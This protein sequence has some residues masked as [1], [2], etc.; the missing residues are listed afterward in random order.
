MFK[1]SVVAWYWRDSQRRTEKHI[2][3]WASD[4]EAACRIA[5]EY[6]SIMD[7]PYWHVTA[8]QL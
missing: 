7:C 6:W 5:A 3:L 1:W 4:K 8:V 2:E